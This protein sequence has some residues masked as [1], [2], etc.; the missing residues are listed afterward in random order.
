MR[1]FFKRLLS[2]SSESK[3]VAPESADDGSSQLL[4]YIEESR[5]RAEETDKSGYFELMSR[6]QG[7]IS[8]RDYSA[9]AELARDNMRQ[10]PEFVD[11]FLLEG[12]NLHDVRLVVRARPQECGAT[13]PRERFMRP[14]DLKCV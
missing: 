13:A 12:G 7:A 8:D 5:R 10:V 4:A 11:L 1:N 6:M 2:S 3:Q 9:A 14:E